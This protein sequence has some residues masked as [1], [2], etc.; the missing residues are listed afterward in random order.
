MHR[1][2]RRTTGLIGER[3][4]DLSQKHGLV[5]LVHEVTPKNQLLLHRSAYRG[6]VICVLACHMSFMALPYGVIGAEKARR[7]LRAMTRR[8]PYRP[9]PL[10]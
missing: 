4:R 5:P 10:F 8:R 9:P 1:F 3:P 2:V 6:D 7:E